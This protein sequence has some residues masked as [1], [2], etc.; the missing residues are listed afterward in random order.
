M[1]KRLVVH[2]HHCIG[3]KACEVACAFTH[4][5]SGQPGTSRCVIVETA[6]DEFVPMLC[7][8]CAEAA[9]VQ[10]CPSGA[11]RKDADAGV[12]RLD[13]SRCVQCMA[14]TVVCPFGNVHVDTSKNRVVK[15]DLCEGFDNEPRCARYCPQECL[16]V[17]LVS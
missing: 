13:Q 14:C 3:C 10:V 17:E 15:C 4:G 12:V 8:Q 7:L 9:C 1:M 11:L 16:T 2:P 5:N 6:T